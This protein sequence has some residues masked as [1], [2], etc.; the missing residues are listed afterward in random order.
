MTN[1]RPIIAGEILQVIKA[2]ERKA[3][4]RK[5]FPVGYVV[6]VNLKTQ[7]ST[8]IGFYPFDTFRE[9][10]EF[11]LLFIEFGEALDKTIQTIKEGLN[12]K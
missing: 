7:K 1:S 11:I 2:G 8:D 9:A 12:I 10:K 4:I 3:L 5:Q 6:Q